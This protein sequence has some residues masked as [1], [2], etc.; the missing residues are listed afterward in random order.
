MRLYQLISLLGL[1]SLMFPT[2]SLLNVGSVPVLRIDLIG[3]MLI[4]TT[5]ILF[6]RI[7]VRVLSVLFLMV[8]L[9][10]LILLNFSVNFSRYYYDTLSNV[11]AS[12][13]L[14][15]FTAIIFCLTSIS[16]SEK[17]QS[18]IVYNYLIIMFFVIIFGIYQY[19]SLNLYELPFDRIHFNSP[20]FLGTLVESQFNGLTR[21]ASIFKEPAHLGFF[22]SHGLVFVLFSKGLFKRRYLWYFWLLLSVLALMMSASISAIFSII[23]FFTYIGAKNFKFK[24]ILWLLV[25]SAVAVASPVGSRLVNIVVDIIQFNPQNFSDGSLATRIMRVYLGLTVFSENM[26]FGIGMNQ[27]GFLTIES[28]WNLSWSEYDQNI[29]FLNFHILGIL[30]DSGIIGFLTWML[31][32]VILINKVKKIDDVSIRERSIGLILINVFAIDLPIFS[33]FRILPLILAL[34]YVKR[35][36]EREQ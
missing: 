30:V 29:Y 17:K 16:I 22:A 14:T 24:Y 36:V 19:I 4:L 11:E 10:I 26:W 31:A 28:L 27:L 1:S 2:M 13:Q 7:R 15:L 5:L 21:A 25:F 20:S 6:D 23:M 33:P 18:I 9:F 12:I 8:F 3:Q 32:L 34:I 35:S